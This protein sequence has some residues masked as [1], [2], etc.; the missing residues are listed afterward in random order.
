MPVMWE[1]HATPEMGERAQAL[2]N[3][4]VLDKC[5]LLV[6]VFWTRIGS[7]TGSAPSGTVEEIRRHVKA[8]RPA[9]VYFSKKPVE[10]DSVDM[11]QYKALVAFRDECKE[12]GL[13]AFYDSLEEFSGTFSGHLA[14]IVRDRFAPKSAADGDPHSRRST[15]LPGASEAAKTILAAASDGGGQILRVRTL[16]GTMISAGG[17]HLTDT[18]D[19]REVARWEAALQDLVKLDFIEPR[20]GKGELFAVTHSGYEF[21]DTFRSIPY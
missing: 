12:A 18:S 21:R 14:Q 9:M 3:R 17:R 13:V 2:I 16:D 19:E 7:P 1:T 5:D 15:A 11:D 8:G 10:L 6:A 4:Q 20:G